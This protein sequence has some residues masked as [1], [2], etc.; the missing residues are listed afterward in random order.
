M[1]D[2]SSL[3][4]FKERLSQHALP[5]FYFEFLLISLSILLFDLEFLLVLLVF[6]FN[7]ILHYLVDFELSYA[8]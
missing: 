2:I 1:D 6:F 3:K 4:E 7:F 5:L 8:I